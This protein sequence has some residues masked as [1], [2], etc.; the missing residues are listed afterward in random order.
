MMRSILG[1]SALTII[2]VFCTPLSAQPREL[3]NKVK[4]PRE[5]I[6]AGETSEK[7]R[8]HAVK[9]AH[10]Q[11]VKLMMAHNI[12]N[13][14]LKIDEAYVE[15]H[16]LENDGRSGE[17]IQLENQDPLKQWVYNFR[18]DGAWWNE[19][20]RQD[21]SVERSAL[22]ARIMTGLS[23]LLLAGFG[24]IRLDEYTNRRFTTFLRVT[25]AIL[26]GAAVAGWWM[27]R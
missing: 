9:N 22:M 8:V 12:D 17:D 3:A 7:A 23:I 13:E 10:D 16:V 21:R 14:N 6:G 1:I 18:T 24:Y 20:V 4:L 19:I 11:V 5:A 27:I 25:G 26:V 15:K 2:W